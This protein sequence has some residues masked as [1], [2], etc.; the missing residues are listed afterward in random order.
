[1]AGKEGVLKKVAALANRD[2]PERTHWVEKGE[3]N[4]TK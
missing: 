4:E 3:A 1:M 2:N